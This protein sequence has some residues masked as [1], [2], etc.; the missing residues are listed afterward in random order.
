MA[1]IKLSERRAVYHCLSRVVAGPLWYNAERDRFGMLGAERFSDEAVL[2]SRQFVNGVFAEYRDR[3]GP[4][5]RTGARS[6]RGLGALRDL[7]TLRDLRVNA[8][9]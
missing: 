3:F 6:L 8:V 7:A 5:R 9:T 1:R 2:G 4:R